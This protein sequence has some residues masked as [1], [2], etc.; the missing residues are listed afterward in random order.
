MVC[1]KFSRRQGGR[2]GRW[3]GPGSE[4]RRT[5]GR[6]IAGAKHQA[7]VF[8]EAGRVA[9]G[10]EPSHP[11]PR[12][13]AQKYYAQKSLFPGR[14]PLLHFGVVRQPLA[15]RSSPLGLGLSDANGSVRKAQR[16]R[17]GESSASASVLDEVYSDVKR[18]IN[19]F[20]GRP[21]CRVLSARLW[22][23][24]LPLLS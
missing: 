19:Y 7:R 16:H 12:R 17:L 11:R 13:Y 2:T 21:A 20:C 8:A 10:R 18:G 24:Y 23:L 6:P 4:D 22:L 15:G 1:V 3:P 9:A 14:C 5:K